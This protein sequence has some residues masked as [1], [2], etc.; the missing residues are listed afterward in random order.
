MSFGL[1]SQFR[2]SI[3]IQTILSIVFLLVIGSNEY[4]S[5][6]LFP[7]LYLLLLLPIM[8]FIITRTNHK[9]IINGMG[10]LNIIILQGFIIVGTIFGIYIIVR[11]NMRNEIAYYLI[12]SVSVHLIYFYDKQRLKSMNEEN[13]DLF[14]KNRD[15]VVNSLSNIDN[16]SSN[17][18]IILFDYP[19]ITLQEKKFVLDKIPY[20]YLHGIIIKPNQQFGIRKIATRKLLTNND[21]GT[22]SEIYDNELI[23]NEFSSKFRTFL[24]RYIILSESELQEIFIQSTSISL[25]KAVIW[26]IEDVKFL[27]KFIF[28]EISIQYNDS[29]TLKVLK[30]V[31]SLR[32][33]ELI[34]K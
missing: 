1:N 23:K 16:L 4:N 28:D 25:R 12:L 18:L 30:R 34:K 32:L 20:G 6:S 29:H 22:L 33:R 31:A 14:L 5:I 8:V 2:I 19:T 27:E 21:F 7:I 13:H 9:I 10:L 11:D 3:L 17:E 26:R 15:F 24:I